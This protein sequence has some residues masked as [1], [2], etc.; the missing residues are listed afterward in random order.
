MP[1]Q[2]DES[3]AQ[4]TEMSLSIDM[5]D[6]MDNAFIQKPATTS[7]PSGRGSIS[8]S[9]DPDRRTAVQLQP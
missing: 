2:A 4:L 6:P 7:W 8:G 5:I 9:Q 3:D 1:R